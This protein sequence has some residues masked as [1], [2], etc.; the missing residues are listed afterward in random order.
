MSGE[1]EVGTIILSLGTGEDD[2]AVG[3]DLDVEGAPRR[4]AY[5]PIRRPF[6]GA[7]PA[8]DSSA[9]VTKRVVLRTGCRDRGGSHRSREQRTDDHRDEPRAYPAHH[10]TVVLGSLWCNATRHG[11]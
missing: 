10:P 6:D 7:V 11:R 5:L 9:A 3:L 2:A 4:A 1:R 8:R